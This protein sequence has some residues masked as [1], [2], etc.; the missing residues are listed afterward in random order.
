MGC[1]AVEM[2]LGTSIRL[3]GKY[4]ENSTS[5]ELSEE[6]TVQPALQYAKTLCS[7]MNSLRYTIPGNPKKQQ[8][9]VDPLL[10]PYPQVFV[11][12]DSVKSLLQQP[13]SGP[14]FVF[15][16]HDKYFVIKKD[17]HTDT[18][19]IDRLRPAL[20]EPI[21]PTGSSVEEESAGTLFFS[22]TFSSEN[23]DIFAGDLDELPADRVYSHKG[24]LITKPKRYRD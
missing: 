15:E 4:F 6:S 7:F 8:T 20:V 10:F 24:R 22:S 3:P 21:S 11:R 12:I 16:R 1:A 5:V 13:Y 18:V 14:H 17:G 9:Y 23:E 2:A 19:S